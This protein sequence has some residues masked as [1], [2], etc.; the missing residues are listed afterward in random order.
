MTRDSRKQFIKLAESRVN[1]TIKTMELIGNLSDKNNYTWD[2]VDANKI[3][4]AL[5]I[6]MEE[7]KNRYKNASQPIYKMNEFKLEKIK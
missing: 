7:L 5:E 2:S 1:Q 3:F 4:L 6:S